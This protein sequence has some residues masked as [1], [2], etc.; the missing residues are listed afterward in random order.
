MNILIAGVNGNIGLELYNNLKDKF[1]IISTSFNQG[2][3]KKNF[4]KLDL[5][6]KEEVL[7]FT[8]NNNNIDILIFLVGLAHSKG[9]KKEFK[10]FEKIN[11]DTLVN[12]LSS[13]K[14]NNCIPSQIIFASTISIYGE[15]F[16]QDIY[17]ENLEGKPYSPYAL[18]KLKA[19][20]Y[21]LDNFNSNSWILRFAPVYSSSF[22]LNIYRR[23]KIW[24][25]PYMVGS[26]SNKFSLCNIKNINLV[27]AGIIKRKVPVGIYNISDSK[28]YSY[29]EL[30]KFLK[31]KWVLIIPKLIVRVLY[32]FGKILNNNFIK[33]NTIKLLSD[34]IF[35][36]KK[37]QLFVKLEAKINDI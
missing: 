17:E 1:R 34:N 2:N 18:T 10:D 31:N 15:R 29:N 35:S 16:D 4:T 37:I 28:Y 36:S 8:T 30:R 33:E 13:F 27:V 32:Y 21:L 26:G 11:H 24:L 23:T 12:L 3:I 5:T 6:D 7:N 14:K 9:K 20:K 22:L 25:I 19:E